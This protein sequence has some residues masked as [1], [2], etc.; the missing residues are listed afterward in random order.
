MAD[1]SDD[2]VATADRH[3]NSSGI[4]PQAVLHQCCM[5]LPLLSGNARKCPEINENVCCIMQHEHRLTEDAK[6]LKRL[7]TP[8]GFEPVTLSLEV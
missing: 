5:E 6:S 7:A 1:M 8:T 3:F 4:V 2:L